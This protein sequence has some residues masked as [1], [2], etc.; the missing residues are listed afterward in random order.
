VT[1]FAGRGIIH[2][3]LGRFYFG[4]YVGKFERNALKFE[5]GLPNRWRSLE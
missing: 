3:Q 5:I 4:V 1:V 2:E